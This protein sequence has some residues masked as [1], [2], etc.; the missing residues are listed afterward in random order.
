[1]INLCFNLYFAARPAD[2]ALSKEGEGDMN[3]FATRYISYTTT[4]LYFIYN[5]H[6][7]DNNGQVTHHM[8]IGKCLV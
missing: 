7:N 8:F 5:K 6:N 2:D 4:D 3:T 1:M